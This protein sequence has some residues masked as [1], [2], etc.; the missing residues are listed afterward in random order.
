MRRRSVA[1]LLALATGAV[2]GLRCRADLRTA[3]AG[4]EAPEVGVRRIITDRATVEF[5]DSGSGPAVLVLHGNGGGWDQGLDWARRRLGEDRRV[6]AVSRFGYLGSTVPRDASTADQADVLAELLDRLELDRVDV[7]TLSAGSA[8][9]LQ[10]AIRHPER[11]RSLVLEAPAV[12]S[13]TPKVPPRPVLR[14]LLRAEFPLWLLTRYPPLVAPMVGASWHRLPDED[15]RELAAIMAT[16]LPMRL[17]I[18]GVL[19]DSYVAI[20]EICSGRLDWDAVRAPTL[21]VTAEDSIVPRPADAAALVDRLADA[22]LLVLATG[23]HTLLGN[24][25]ELRRVYAGF[26]GAREPVEAGRPAPPPTG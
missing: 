13:P 5:T 10:L 6:L 19:F 24:V 23:G 12:P 14:A 15:K 4:L 7:V 20:P 8:A 2:A 16:T 18:D 26:L 21:V 25:A 9:G 11:V 22:R 1:G 3:Q 17:R